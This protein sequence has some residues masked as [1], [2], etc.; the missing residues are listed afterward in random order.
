MLYDYPD[1]MFGRELKLKNITFEQPAPETTTPSVVEKTTDSLASDTKNKTS[2]EANNN[3][4]NNPN[5]GTQSVADMTQMVAVVLIA[6]LW[7]LI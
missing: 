3:A 2:P 5:M 6:A 4:P 7:N 1:Q